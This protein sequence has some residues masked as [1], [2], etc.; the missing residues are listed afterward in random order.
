MTV[1]LRIRDRVT[2][3]VTLEITDRVTRIIGRVYTG[4]GPG[5]IS[6]PEFV[7]GTGWA[8]PLVIE[9]A[10]LRPTPAPLIAISSSGMSWSFPGTGTG[11]LP[12][13]CWITY[14]V[15]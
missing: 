8:I 12:V 13:G 1:G 4:A 3:V 9:Q 11:N 2:G 10:A 7:D 6:V 5:S 14:G 15:W